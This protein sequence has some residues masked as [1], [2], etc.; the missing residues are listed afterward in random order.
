MGEFGDLDSS[1]SLLF[2]LPPFC[3][4]VSTASF[5]SPLKSLK[6]SLKRPS[7]DRRSFHTKPQPVVCVCVCV[8]VFVF[9]FVWWNF[10]LCMVTSNSLLLKLTEDYEQHYCCNSKHNQKHSYRNLHNHTHL[11]G[12]NTRGALQL[13]KFTGRRL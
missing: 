1:M 3:C 5:L 13:E 6:S 8:C 12:A 4:G 7:R 9:V 10:S 2:L 11:K